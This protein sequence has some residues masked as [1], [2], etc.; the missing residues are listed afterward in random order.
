MNWPQAMPFCSTM[1]EP[2]TTIFPSGWSVSAWP[3]S[4]ELMVVATA[5][6]SPKVVSGDP[7][8]L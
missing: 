8:A 4:P 5:P 7:S 6:P 1:L 2:A 3:E